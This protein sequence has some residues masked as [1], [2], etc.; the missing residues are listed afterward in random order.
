[1]ILFKKSLSQ[2]LDNACQLA[3]DMTL[4][5]TMVESKMKASTSSPQQCK[6]ASKYTA[7]L[8]LLTD[9]HGNFR[10]NI[11]LKGLKCLNDILKTIKE[12]I[13]HILQ[14]PVDYLP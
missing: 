5:V 11:P 9:F 8:S 3:K 4:H 10:N 13:S 7:F 14:R 1:M 6:E 2:S 12:T